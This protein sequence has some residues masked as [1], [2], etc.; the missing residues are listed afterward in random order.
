MATSGD[1]FMATDKTRPSE[2]ALKL[3]HAV[4]EHQSAYEAPCR[5][6]RNAHLSSFR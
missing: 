3:L 1:F 2:P 4:P 6:L 5:Q